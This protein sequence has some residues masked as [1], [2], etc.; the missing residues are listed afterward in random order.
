MM[1]TC[2]LL[3]ALLGGCE[4]AIA[5]DID[6][7]DDAIVRNGS[8]VNLTGH[9]LPVPAVCMNGCPAEVMAA[10]RDPSLWVITLGG[11]S[12]PGGTGWCLDGQA[13]AW[14]AMQPWNYT[15]NRKAD[16]F[17]PTPVGEPGPNPT[18]PRPLA[19]GGLQNVDCVENP[20]FCKAS[21]AMI[22]GCD[23]GVWMGDGEATFS[24]KLNIT[25]SCGGKGQPSC[26]PNGNGT[27]NG[28]KVTGHGRHGGNMLGN[29]WIKGSTKL[30]FRGQSILRESIKTLATLGMAKATHVLLT[31]VVWS[32]TGVVLHA[33][34][35]GALLK[36]AIPGLQV[37]KA[38]PVDAVHPKFDSMQVVTDVMH[39]S[40]NSTVPTTCDFSNK[41]FVPS[42]TKGCVPVPDCDAVMGQRE[43]VYKPD[44]A[45]YVG[46]WMDN[47]LQELD[48]RALLLILF[49]LG[50]FVRS[51]SLVWPPT[52]AG[53]TNASGPGVQNWPRGCVDGNTP[54]GNKGQVSV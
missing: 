28:T 36:A 40:V 22:S 54:S 29:D 6:A 20:V 52:L 27:Y 16:I 31:G 24:G 45:I 34:T 47:Q 8:R 44:P 1:M 17:C 11:L 10:V 53:V 46:T 2:V 30:H 43:C 49:V 48:D 32:G 23:L 9:K 35:I 15:S 33:D 39:P 25:P 13:C 19:D 26:L 18:P 38:L 3:L 4:G 14:E 21:H 51:W 5:V 50:H 42:P 7:T 41:T 12:A 37:Y